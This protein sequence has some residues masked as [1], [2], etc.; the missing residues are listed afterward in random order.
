M[1][2]YGNNASRLSPGTREKRQCSRE[3]RQSEENGDNCRFSLAPGKKN[4][5]KEPLALFPGKEN[6]GKGPF[7]LPLGKESGG[8]GLRLCRSGGNQRHSAC[9]SGYQLTWSPAGAD[10][11]DPTFNRFDRED[12]VFVL[13]KWMELLA[14]IQQARENQEQEQK[15]EAAE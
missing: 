15:A 4:S 5:G 1:Q 12:A 11:I 2:P 8:K 10:H 7:S 6:S 9:A 3:W 14:R 13:A